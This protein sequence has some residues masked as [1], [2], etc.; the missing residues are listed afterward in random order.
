MQFG[1]INSKLFLE[2]MNTSDED[3]DENNDNMCLISSSPLITNFITLPCN[4]S[5][6]YIPL[7]KAIIQQ[8]S[9]N[10]LNILQLH[11][12]Q[13]QCPYCR[14]IHHKLLPFIP[15]DEFNTPLKNINSPEKYCMTCF[16]CTWRFTSGK[17]KNTTCCKYGYTGEN[18]TYCK[19]HHKLIK[20]VEILLEWNHNTMHKY[21]QYTNIQLKEMLKELNQKTSGEKRILIRRIVTYKYML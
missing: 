4:H 9:K 20:K 14:H 6:N 21:K 13:L 18:G 11:S 2:A 15:N 17:K 19:T 3:E 7:L 10:N 12:H 1:H 16:Q 8:K 5:F